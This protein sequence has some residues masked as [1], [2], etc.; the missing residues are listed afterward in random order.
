MKY[1]IAALIILA[2][3]QFGFAATLRLEDLPLSGMR[4]DWGTP[5]AG[6]SVERNQFSIGGRTFDHGVG[7]HAVSTWWINLD[8]VTIHGIGGRR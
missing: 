1:R 4:Q 6:K 8:G 5:S 7:T 2:A 3:C